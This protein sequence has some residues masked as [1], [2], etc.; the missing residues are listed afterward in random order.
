MVHQVH[1]DIKIKML[2][3]LINSPSHDPQV[4]ITFQDDTLYPVDIGK[5]RTGRPRIKWIDNTIDL[6]WGRITKAK[7]VQYIHTPID[8]DN[9][10]HVHTLRRAAKD[11]YLGY[12]T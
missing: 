11:M 12:V 9:Q 6:A 2:Y 7:Y 8:P 3:R 4:K 5:R 10:A 1:H